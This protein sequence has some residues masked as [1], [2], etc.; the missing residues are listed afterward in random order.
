[1]L[2]TKEITSFDE[3]YE[4]SWSGAIDTLNDIQNADKEDELMDYLEAV[5]EGEATSE[6]T[7]NDFL[8]FD[9]TSIYEAL[10]LDENGEEAG[11]EKD[12]YV[13][14]EDTDGTDR[15][16]C[17]SYYTVR[18]LGDGTLNLYLN[19]NKFSEDVDTEE[20]IQSILNNENGRVTEIEIDGVIEY[21]TDEE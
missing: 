11:E 7:V 8:W 4:N 1:M 6:T 20:I 5:F 2:V 12:I 18:E 13:T 10:G 9:R 21:T 15:T 14:I 17:V 3:L 19:G 16:R